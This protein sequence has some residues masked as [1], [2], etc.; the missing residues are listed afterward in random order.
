M[1]VVPSLNLPSGSAWFGKVAGLYYC[2]LTIRDV[3]RE[4]LPLRERL[5][6]Q[7]DGSLGEGEYPRLQAAIGRLNLKS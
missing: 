1:F 2:S 6:A 4:V 3:S 7:H 5:Y